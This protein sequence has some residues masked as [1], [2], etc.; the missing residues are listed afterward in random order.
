MHKAYDA[1]SFEERE[2][3]PFEDWFIVMQLELLVLVYVRSLRESNFSLYV[4][5][6]VALTPWF[7]ALDHTHYSRWVPIHIRDMMTLHERHPDVASQFAQGGFV[8]HKTSILIDSYHP[9][10]QNNK[11]VKG[12]GGAVGLLQNPRALLRWMVAGPE[13]ARVIEECEINC[14]YR[15]SGNIDTSNLKH[16]E[17]TN[18]V[19]VTLENTEL[20]VAFGTGKHLRYIPAHAIATA[21]GDEKARSLPMFHSIRCHHLQVEGKRLHLTS[22]NPSMKSLQYS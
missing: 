15:C 3:I 13:L 4:A 20:W 17:D 16:H 18:S 21:L 8:V 9:H 22:G 19:Q 6:L 14:L 2:P 10:E 11:I 5:V 1:Y 7:F 12:D